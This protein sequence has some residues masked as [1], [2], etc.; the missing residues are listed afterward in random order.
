MNEINEAEWKQLQLGR[1]DEAR[2]SGR[3]DRAARTRVHGI[4]PQHFFS[5]ASSECRDLFI[6]GHFYGCISL[7]Q[8]VAE[9]LTRYLGDFHKIGARKDP[10]VRATRLFKANVFSSDSLEALTTI[11]GNDRN[12]FHHLNEN[13]PT[14]YLTLETRA[15]QCVTAL[16]TIESELFAYESHDGGLRPK[17]PQ[18]WPFPDS[19]HVMT[20]LRL[21]GY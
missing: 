5:G 9:G 16:Y 2:F 3:A 18:Y 19:Q 15:E 10:P 20:N 17:N 8:A 7:A 21:S 11:W 6:D 4:I 14:D 13:I 1:T 12:T